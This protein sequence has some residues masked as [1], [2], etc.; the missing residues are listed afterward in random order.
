[1]PLD[2]LLSR[3]VSWVARHASL[4]LLVV[5]MISLA[6]GYISLTRFAMNSDLSDLIDQ[7]APWRVDF[8]RFEA[9]FPDLVRTAVVV[10]DSSSI[11]DLETTTEALLTRLEQYPEKFTAVAA[12]GAEPFFRDHAFLYM[13]VDE[14]DD[15]TDR[16]AEAQPWLTTVA[17]DASLRGVLSLL[18]DGVENDPPE[19]FDRVV[20]L[21]SASGTRA[22]A[23]ESA[24][25]AWSDELF[26]VDERLY[27]LV[28]LKAGELDGETLTDAELVAALRDVVASLDI[29]VGTAV[30]LTG[31][32]PLQH[33]E[34][35]AAVGGV[36]MA[37]WLSLALLLLVMLVGVRSIKIIIATFSMLAIGIIWTTA[38]ALLSV[39]EY[40]TLSIVFIVMFFG[41]GVDFALHFSLRYQQAINATHADVAAALATSAGSV[42]RAISLCTLTTGLG[43]L[44]FLPTEYQ[45]LADLGVISAGGMLVAW[46][47]TFSY[48]P[49]F[50]ALVGPPRD[51]E[52]DLPS[53]T[54]VVN[55]LLARRRLVLVALA[56]LGIGAVVV[57]SQARFDYSVLALKD[58]D[59]ESMSTLRELQAEGLSTDYQLVVVSA[60]DDD[61]LP[62]DVLEGLGAVDEV[63]TLDA[64]V[65][66]NQD[67][68]LYALEDIRFMLWSALEPA[69]T[70]P[71]PK[72]AELR[73]QAAALAAQIENNATALTE[74]RSQ[75]LRELRAVLEK[76]QSAPDAMW[77]Q[78]QQGATAN[79][80]E[81]LA[82]L[83]RAI[84]VEPVD[85]TD[86][87]ASVR[88]R[89]VNEHGE[90]LSSIT[91][92]RDIAQ[93]AAL[94]EFIDSV[95][96]LQPHA[97][98]RPVIEWGVGG[99]VVGSF[100]QA[101]L[102]AAVTI[103][104]VLLIALRRV[105]SVLLILLPLLLTG[106][107]TL[108][109]GVLAGYP[110]NMA[111][112]I[113][114]PL[115]FGLGVDNG[116]HVV[117]RY[118]GEGDVEHLMHSS[119]PRA[120][121]LSALTTVGAFAAL[122]TSPHAGTASIGLLLTV[123]VGLLLLLTIFALPVLLADGVKRR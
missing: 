6:C 98:G 7:S 32:L 99:I 25:I 77:L 41:L 21:L 70:L 71:S 8:D 79:L 36:T 44:G 107:M 30:R 17:E 45:G 78:W 10:V 39:G 68:K 86:L 9:S 117:D 123:A 40:N 15:M 87:P 88:T 120:V 84:A 31:E 65:P 42:G 90:R 43:F 14:L 114:L 119:T 4:T 97:T 101:L 19:G 29:P 106:V 22:L 27:Q 1:M 112:I 33:E 3:W 24:E 60:P 56:V 26:G 83:R 111:N 73:A 64:L 85:L 109:L 47:L 52:M 80:L 16:L 72:V 81:E 102:F 13:S 94:S 23:G 122:S 110:L 103:C 93:V 37:G 12:P 28:Y 92:S 48:L 2:H 116:I 96:A 91:P 49:A 62:V 95:R 18:A 58:P 121:L 51:H 118:F 89:V 20:D 76:M 46:L 63:R 35:E 53:S 34:L 75:V 61:P 113:V 108:A 57:A 59:S 55:A 54:L 104:A 82:W 50:Y 67:D 69:R 105:R 38:F 5:G 66:S 11:R 115:I 74:D 100:V